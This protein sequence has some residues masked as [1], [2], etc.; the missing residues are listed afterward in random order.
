MSEQGKT[1]SSSCQDEAQPSR[2][3]RINLLNRGKGQ[4]KITLL[5]TQS[6]TVS[7]PRI[8]CNNTPSKSSHK[9]SGNGDALTLTSSLTHEFKPNKT[10]FD[11]TGRFRKHLSIIL[12]RKKPFAMG[13]DMM[14]EFRQLVIPRSI[15][16]FE[17]E[18]HKVGFR[19]VTHHG[20]RTRRWKYGIIASLH[21][22]AKLQ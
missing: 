5:H 4:G 7:R 9:R 15:T 17:K 18:K 21:L 8:C 13:S 2:S 14:R 10:E 6:W 11:S 19:Y 1:P 16:N 3:L 20:S 12:P 22:N